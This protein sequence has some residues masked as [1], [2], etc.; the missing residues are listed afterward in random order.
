MDVRV[1]LNKLGF[2]RLGSMYLDKDGFMV[3][4]KEPDRYEVYD[5]YGK[6]AHEGI[7]PKS[8]DEFKKIINTV[9]LIKPLIRLDSTKTEVFNVFVTHD[10]D[11]ARDVTIERI[12]S[13]K[14]IIWNGVYNTWL[15]NKAERVW[16]KQNVDSIDFSDEPTYEKIYRDL[17]NE[18][19]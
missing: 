14:Y 13:S 6:L 12:E 11:L 3:I 15:F 4:L 1:F 19:R 2:E 8:E 10:E 16:K 5:R 17:N 9:R 7:I 18:T